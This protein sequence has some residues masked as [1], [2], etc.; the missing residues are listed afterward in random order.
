MGVS[1]IR[2]ALAIVT[3]ASFTP[4]RLR[5]A[6]PPEARHEYV[7]AHMA[8]PFKILL[9]TSDDARA[10]RASR[11]AFDR[12]EALNK[13]L[14]DYDPDSELSRLGRA[15]GG[16]PQRVSRDL[17]DV[18]AR[19]QEYYRLSGGV[20]DV[21]IAP[22]GRLW[23]RARRDRKLPAADTLA[24]AMQLVGGDKLKLDPQASTAQLCLHGMRLD[25]GGIAK[26]YAAEAALSVLKEQGIKRALVAAAGDIV[27]GDPPPG[28]AGWKIAIA[29][30]DPSQPEP[31]RT[32]LLANQAVSTAGDAEQFV[33]I[34]GRRY[35]HIV[36]PK[37]GMGVEDRASVTVV[38]PDGAAADALE[39]VVYLLG[40]DRGL[41][42]V[43]SLP[44]TSAIY[45]RLTPG[46]VRRFESKRF[47]DVPVDA[48]TASP[49]PAQPAPGD[50]RTRSKSA[51]KPG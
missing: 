46:G 33:V 40:P 37:T 44:G 30:V 49:P 32:L 27:V 16:A 42:L 38:A 2:A 20:F 19:S 5:A 9:Y 21:T 17:F 45:L 31:E 41:T 47:K 29:P 28:Q 50:E 22:V 23:R 11:L 6:D 3:V 4:S 13:T 35:S 8:V 25:V 18:L 7:E 10:S 36:N 24:R 1:G 14:S 12:I 43:D 48:R 34:N 39:T 26:G 51:Q 15:S